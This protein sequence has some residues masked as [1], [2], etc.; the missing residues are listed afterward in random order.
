MPIGTLYIYTV[1]SVPYI[2]SYR[3]TILIETPKLVKNEL[4]TSLLL[5][6]ASLKMKM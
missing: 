2:K 3:E 6:R 1:Y 5:K 4:I